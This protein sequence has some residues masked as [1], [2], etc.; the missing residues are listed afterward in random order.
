MNIFRVIASA[1]SKA[2]SLKPAVEANK[3]VREIAKATRDSRV[4]EPV[5]MMLESIRN[6][7]RGWR[8]EIIFPTFHTASNSFN[9]SSKWTNG[10]NQLLVSVKVTD[11]NVGEVYMGSIWVDERSLYGA[12]MVRGTN[13]LNEYGIIFSNAVCNY[14]SWLNLTEGRD[15]YYALANVMQA[16]LTKVLAYQTREA[17]RTKQIQ[18][19]RVQQEHDDERDRLI[20]VYKGAK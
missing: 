11:R 6:N 8:V 4:S 19:I 2:L 1:I 18:K 16:R 3:A 7:P 10:T 5:W 15:L 14:P 13:V 17:T 20:A 9:T 12:Y